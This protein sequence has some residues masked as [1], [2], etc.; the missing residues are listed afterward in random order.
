MAY[1]HGDLERAAVDGAYARVLSAPHDDLSVRELADALGVTPRAIYRHVGD[2]RGL[3]V[4]VAARAFEELCGEV[5]R[6]VAATPAD[7]RA[8]TMSAYVAFAL[9][10]PTRYR[11]MYGMGDDA[12][13]QPDALGDQVR[14][15]I[16]LTERA[17]ADAAPGL[18]GRARRDH[19]I[20]LWG[21]CHGLVE[22]YF[23]GTLR[24]A[25][26]AQAERYIQG[27]MLRMIQDA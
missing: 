5:E 24:A 17:V 13:R 23:G 15:L 20:G 11:L 3:L 26:P 14:R 6:A 1:H 16:A 9:A 18:T 10:S 21:L 7:A 4:A 22:L 19:I 27:Q 2:R 12:L 8:A 25:S